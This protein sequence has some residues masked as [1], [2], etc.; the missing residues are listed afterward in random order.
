MKPKKRTWAGWGCRVRIKLAQQ[1]L[2]ADSKNKKLDSLGEANIPPKSKEALLNR[3]FIE[4][5][6]AVDETRT[7]WAICKGK[8]LKTLFKYA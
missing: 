5:S 2:E 4:T 3:V 6:K 1:Y 7:K 8:I